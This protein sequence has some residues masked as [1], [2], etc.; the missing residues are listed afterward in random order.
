M[1][2]PYCPECKCEYRE[3]FSMCSDCRVD[4]VQVLE[5]KA[6]S[7]TSGEDAP[8]PVFSSSQGGEAAIVK[9]ILEQAGIPVMEQWKPKSCFQ[10]QPFSIRVPSPLDEVLLLVPESLAE[11]ARKLLEQFRQS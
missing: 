8:V 11:D 7:K 3:G 9:S 5:E 2:M 10:I 1:H 4:L 6:Q